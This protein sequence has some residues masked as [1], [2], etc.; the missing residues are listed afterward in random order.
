LRGDLIPEA[1]FRNREEH[2]KQ[3]ILRLRS[4][5]VRQRTGIRNRIH[6]LIDE[7]CCTEKI[8]NSDKHVKEFYEAD[9]DCKR[10]DTIPGFGAFLSVLAKV[11]IGTIDRFKSASHLCSYVGVIPT[12]TI[13]TKNRRN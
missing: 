10:I 12:T 11:G 13:P 1:Y 7:Q 5:W 8:R 6:C 9:Q 4:F 2:E 3:E